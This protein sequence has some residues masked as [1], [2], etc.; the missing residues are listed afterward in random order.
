MY[1]F[2]GFE[3]VVAGDFHLGLTSDSVLVDGIP[4]RLSDTRVRLREAIELASNDE[5][6]TLI[7]VGDLFN[8]VLLDP[9]TVEAAMDCFHYA[10]E[11]LTRIF[12]IPGNHDCDVKWRA[13]TLAKE[14][15]H[16]SLTA[17]HEPELLVKNNKEIGFFLPHMPR[18]REM[19]FLSVRGSYKKFMEDAVKKFS[20]SVLR[21][22]HAL[23]GHAHMK[24]ATNAAG[25]DISGYGSGTAM[26]FVPKEFPSFFSV[27]ILGHVHRHQVISTNKGYDVLYTGPA[28][29]TNFSEAEIEKGCIKL[30]SKTHEWKFIPYKS[31]VHE[32][33]H[34]KINLVDRK[35]LPNL[36][37]EKIKRTLSGKLLKITVF[38]RSAFQVDEAGL[39]KVFNKYATVMRMEYKIESSRSAVVKE[40]KGVIPIESLNHTSL[41]RSFVKKSD[42]ASEI[43][44]RAL[45]IGKEV[46][47]EC[48]GE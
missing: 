14:F 42:A 19:D 33:R 28:I 30:N 13:T 11:K 47:N 5:D 45:E 46:I 3:L 23:F 21:K 41:L 37:E 20:P 40:G 26:D 32:Y 48:C 12:L 17:V 38:A 31:K 22:K 1:L 24:G 25:F 8:K 2:R 15:R 39:K 43:K 7:I 6:R 34:V 18:S 29:T 4:S 9:M 35:G 27:V 10:E 44:D 16:A 36:D